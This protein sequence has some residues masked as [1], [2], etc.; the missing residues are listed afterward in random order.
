M[1]KQ[2]FL[3]LMEQY[4]VAAAIKSVADQEVALQSR[5]M[6][7]FLLKGDA[8]S[9]GDFLTRAHQR[10]KAVSIHLDLISGIGKDRAGIQYLRQQGV[11]AIITSRSHLIAAGKAEGLITIQRLLLLESSALEVGIKS[12]VRSQPDIVEVLPGVIFPDMVAR[13]RQH[14]ELPL[15]TGGFIRSFADVERVH[16]AGAML[17]STSA[18]EL[19]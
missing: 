14:L 15:I 1:D 9:L 3:H 4:P 11:D 5:A 16:K 19:W 10:K 13:L 12:I 6:L 8:F 18:Q 2:A 17:C 7:L